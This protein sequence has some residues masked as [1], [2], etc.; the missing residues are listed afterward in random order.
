[1]PAYSEWGYLGALVFLVVSFGA[2]LLKRETASQAYNEKRDK[3]W[4]D[5]FTSISAGN[6]TD[7]ADMR[8]TAEHLVKSLDGLM[9]MYSTHDTRAQTILTAIEAI[10][11]DVSKLAR[12]PRATK[13]Q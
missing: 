10:K 1:M 4:R 3:E 12:P 5:F 7:I 13:I 6:Q 8:A 2:F 11:A 9:A